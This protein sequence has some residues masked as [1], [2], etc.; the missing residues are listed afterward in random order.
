MRIQTANPCE[1]SL[2]SDFLGTTVF[3]FFPTSASS[4]NTQGSPL[5]FQLSARRSP[6]KTPNFGAPQDYLLP[7]VPH[8]L[9]KL[10]TTEIWDEPLGRKHAEG[11]LLSG[12]LF[13]LRSRPLRT[14][15]F[16]ASSVAHLR[17]VK[18]SLIQHFELLP[19]GL[20]RVSSP[21][22]TANGR[23]KV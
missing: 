18:K 19:G 23:P 5:R 17:T 14:P 2:V 16:L 1:G 15:P 21:P 8:I 20:F 10:G 6:I 22:H 9:R 12:V 3:F 4:P 7:P 13:S 11:L